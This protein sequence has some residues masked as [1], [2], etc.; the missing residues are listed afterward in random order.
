MKAYPSCLLMLAMMVVPLAKGDGVADLVGRAEKG[1]AAAQMEL[2]GIYLKGEGVTKDVAEAVKWLSKAAELGNGDAQMKLG[3]IYLGG[4]G[5]L[6][7][8]LEAFFEFYPDL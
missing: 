4:R 2:A 1:E 8:S 5:V 6:K 7:N 3:G